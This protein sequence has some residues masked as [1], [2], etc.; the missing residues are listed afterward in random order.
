[1]SAESVELEQ[2]VQPMKEYFETV[3]FLGEIDERVRGLMDVYSRRLLFIAA[4]GDP[5][6]AADVALLRAGEIDLSTAVDAGVVV[7]QIR[8][9]VFTPF[10]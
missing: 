5:D 1:M 10:A 7:D 3:R 6:V 8:A 4:T 2:N 9:S